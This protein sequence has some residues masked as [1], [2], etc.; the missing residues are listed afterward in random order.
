MARTAFQQLLLPE[1]LEDGGDQAKVHKLPGQKDLAGADRLATA[2]F[3]C[4]ALGLQRPGWSLTLPE[5]FEDGKEQARVHNLLS[6]KDL[7]GADSLATAI[8]EEL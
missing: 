1:E 5:E 2:A 6:Q 3:T 7:V 8:L 4:T